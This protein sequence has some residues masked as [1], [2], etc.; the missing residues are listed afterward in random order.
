MPYYL[1][2]NAAAAEARERFAA[3]EACY[4]P[5]TTARL[6]TLGIGEGWR[7]LEVGAGSGSVANWMADSVGETGSVLATDIETGLIKGVRSNV[8]V[9]RH[10]IVVD[11]LPEAAFDL[12]HSRLVLQH[13]PERM[14][15][16][17]RILRSLRPGGRL[18]LDAFDCTW[19]P[20]LRAPDETSAVVFSSVVDGIHELLERAGLDLAWGRHAYG[21]MVETGYT[22]LAV[23]G[24]CE[25]WVGGSTGMRLHRANALQTQDRL[26]EVDLVTKDDLE[27]FFTTLEDPRFAV[28]SYLM[29]ST[30]GRRPLA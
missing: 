11:D 27:A 20:V 5:V 15:V 24:H 26:F 1:F 10:D 6:T 14:R 16:L 2:D 3:L 29:L 12:V 23:R 22:E 25:A 4:D 19:L 7:C 17:R 13:L 21:A 18:L 9:R 8:E 28:S 30:T